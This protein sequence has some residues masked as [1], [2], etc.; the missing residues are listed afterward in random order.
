VR[1]TILTLILDPHPPGIPSTF[2]PTSCSRRSTRRARGSTPFP[3][4][5]SL[6]EATAF[7][8]KDLERLDPV[9]DRPQAEKART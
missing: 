1:G 5:R 4:K 3:I 2:S 9:L 8:L 7:A 6:S